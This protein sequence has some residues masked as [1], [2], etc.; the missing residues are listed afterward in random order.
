MYEFYTS[1]LAGRSN[2]VCGVASDVSSLEGRRLAI[3]MEGK[4]ISYLDN[5]R[6]TKTVNGRCVE[7]SVETTKKGKVYILLNEAQNGRIN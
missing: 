4:L 2:Y 1:R 3:P 7:V 5:I 6:W